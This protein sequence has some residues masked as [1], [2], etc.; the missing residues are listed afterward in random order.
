M[1]NYK[2]LQPS[3]QSST[4]FEV[5]HLR[6][7]CSTAAS[8]PFGNAEENKAGSDDEDNAEDDDDPGFLGSP[9]ISF[10]ELIDGFAQLQSLECGDG[11][12]FEN[13]KKEEVSN[14]RIVLVY[15]IN[16]QSRLFCPIYA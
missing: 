9:V 7:S 14:E 8:E 3:P 16:I 11:C 15:I 2:L 6:G 5:Q 13:L 12:H 10:C 1:C 4:S